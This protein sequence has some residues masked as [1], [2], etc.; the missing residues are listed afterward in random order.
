M[1]KLAKKRNV[2]KRRHSAPK[3]YTQPETLHVE[4]IKQFRKLQSSHVNVTFNLT[5]LK[6]E[7]KKES[8]QNLAAKREIKPIRRQKSF[9]MDQVSPGWRSVLKPIE[10]PTLINT[11]RD[12]FVAALE[13]ASWKVRDIPDLEQQ[14]S[15]EPQDIQCKLEMLRNICR[16]RKDPL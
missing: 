12:G 15:D 2:Y 6:E 11:G 8:T 4:V 1:Q 10:E 16:R 7:A 14:S 13:N 3:N 9:V 5:P